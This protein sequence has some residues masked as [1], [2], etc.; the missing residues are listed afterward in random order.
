[1]NTKKQGMGGGVWN[2]NGKVVSSTPIP[3]FYFFKKGEGLSLL[4]NS[5]SSIH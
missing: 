5:Y 1:M 3:I 4:I 2:L